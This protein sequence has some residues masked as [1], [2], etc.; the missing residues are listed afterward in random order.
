MLCK[1]CQGQKVLPCFHSTT[2]KNNVSTDNSH[3]KDYPNPQDIE[4][5]AARLPQPGVKQNIALKLICHIHM[6]KEQA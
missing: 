3:G 5:Q 6:L 2:A 1:H 4:V